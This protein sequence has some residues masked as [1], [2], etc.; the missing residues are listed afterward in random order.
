MEKEILTFINL[1]IIYETAISFLNSYLSI[2][3][4][5]CIGKICNIDSEYVNNNM[6]L[7][8]NITLVICKV[9]TIL[10]NVTMI[11]KRMKTNNVIINNVIINN[12]NDIKAG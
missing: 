1:F 11:I 8:K 9:I 3:E 7:L 4:H 5:L 6:I 2:I 12:D 10:A